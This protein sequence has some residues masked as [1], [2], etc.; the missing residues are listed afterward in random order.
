M[1]AGQEDQNS[2]VKVAQWLAQASRGDEAAWQSLVEEFAPRI[3][4]LLRAQR[5]DADLAEELTQSVFATLVEK[6]AGYTEQ[7]QFEAWIFRVAMNRLRDEMRRRSRHA[8][9]GSD[10]G[11]A[12]A[13]S[14][15]M[16]GEGYRTV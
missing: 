4:G 5:I 3:F 14:T 2:N 12:T 9:T 13:K 1:R 8:K 15:G 6:L 16:A 7:G 11:I 10:D